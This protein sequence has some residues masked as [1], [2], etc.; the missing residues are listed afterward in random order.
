[1]TTHLR[2][3]AA[4]AGALLAVVAGG[5]AVGPAVALADPPNVEIT[6]LNTDV[7]AGGTL[8]L[9]Y[10]VT[11]T[12][13]GGGQQATASVRVSGMKCSGECGQIATIDQGSRDFSAQLTAPAVDQIGRAHV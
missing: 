3:R 8:T 6:N 5:I 2:A 11:N 10:R 13:N 1:M 4:Q 9:Q 12:N 7:A